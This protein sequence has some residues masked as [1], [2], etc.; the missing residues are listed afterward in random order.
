MLFLA[1]SILHDAIHFLKNVT[2]LWN[3]TIQRRLQH[4]PIKFTNPLL[5]LPAPH[6]P[7]VTVDGLSVLL[8]KDCPS[9][10]AP[11]PSPSAY[12][13]TWVSFLIVIFSL[14]S[15]LFP[16]A[17]KYRVIPPI[18]NRA[19]QNN[20]NL[21]D[22]I[23]QDSCFSVSLLTVTPKFLEI[24]LYPSHSPLTRLLSWAHCIQAFVSATLQRCLWQ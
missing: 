21:L 8:D 10:C 18:Q 9:T 11:V 15:G 5:C 7:S 13:R 14:S 12:S 20:T 2:M 16:S 19:K 3:R 1:K 24:F 4:T 6:F 17:Y 22:S 23:S